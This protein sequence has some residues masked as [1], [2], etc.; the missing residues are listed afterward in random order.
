MNKLLPLFAFLFVTPIFAAEKTSQVQ[1]TARYEGLD[2]AYGYVES[3]ETGSKSQTDLSM[4]KVT[5]KSDR[6]VFVQVARELRV[7]SR[8]ENVTKD[9]GM[10]LD[11]TPTIEGQAIKASGKSSICALAVPLENI[12]Q[13]P[14]SFKNLETYFNQTFPNNKEVAI[15]LSDDIPGTLYLT[16]TLL[17]RDGQPIK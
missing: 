1:V 9:I 16:F 17:G 2:P 5:T 15:K 8:P 6:Q 13:Q 4:P 10:T 7:P 14:I 12:T 11:I 3:L